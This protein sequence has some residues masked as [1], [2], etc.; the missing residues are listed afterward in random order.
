MSLTFDAYKQKVE[1][2]LQAVID[3]HEKGNKSRAQRELQVLKEECK[4]YKQTLTQCKTAEKL[5]DFRRR[6]ENTLSEF[7]ANVGTPAKGSWEND[8][9][10]SINSKMDACIS[11]LKQ[12]ETLI[13]SGHGPDLTETNDSLDFTVQISKSLAQLKRF[14]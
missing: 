1:T 9:F 2:Y 14:L 3:Y 13:K 7:C 10:L 12:M 4:V 5:M 6:M 11:S 8:M